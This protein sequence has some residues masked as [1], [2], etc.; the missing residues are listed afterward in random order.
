[1][2]CPTK[3]ADG[4]ATA[5]SSGTSKSP[6][7][8]SPIYDALVVELGDPAAWPPIGIASV[9]RPTRRAKRWFPAS[10]ARRS[11]A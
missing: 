11:V 4:K 2:S 10:E 3:Q 1:M 9:K 8:G 7:A 6:A 5:P